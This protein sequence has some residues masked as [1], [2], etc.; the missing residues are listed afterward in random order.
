[1]ADEYLS[2]QDPVDVVPVPETY[3]MF[4]SNPT[5]DVPY[6]VDIKTL[7]AVSRIFFKKPGGGW[8]QVAATDDNDLE[9]TPLTDLP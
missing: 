7:M 5:G 6:K 3:I 8:L 4:V 2:A 9:L 1:M